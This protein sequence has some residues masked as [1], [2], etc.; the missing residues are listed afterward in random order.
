[1]FFAGFARF[2][3]AQKL[4]DLLFS[5]AQK[6][7]DLPFSACKFQLAACSQLA[8]F[9]LQIS[10]HGVTECQCWREVAA[11]LISDF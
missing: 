9:R 1:M 11:F 10:A 3:A 2:S 6:L 7:R 5:A 8:N 4:R